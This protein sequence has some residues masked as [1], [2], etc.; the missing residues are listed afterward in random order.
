[1]KKSTYYQQCR[2]KEGQRRSDAMRGE[3]S[4]VVDGF[5]KKEMKR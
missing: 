4:Q 2:R 3:A 5:E 1:M